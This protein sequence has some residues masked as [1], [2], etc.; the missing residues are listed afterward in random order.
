MMRARAVT[1]LVALA[2]LLWSSSGS[3]RAVDRLRTVKPDGAGPFPAVLFV[4]GCSGFAPPFAPSAYERPAE[5]LRT[6]G[7][8]VTYVDYLAARGLKTCADALTLF[9]PSE[10]GADLHAEAEGDLLAAATWLGTQPFVDPA[11]ITALGW[12]WGGGVVL[13]TLLHT[14]GDRLGFSRAI[15]YYPDCRA[16]GAWNVQTPLLMLI[17]GADTVMSRKACEAAAKRSAYSDA[18]KVVVYEGAMQGFDVEELP[19]KMS[20]PFGTLGHDP[21]AA[22][23]AWQ[24]IMRF[25]SRQP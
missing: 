2:L 14:T 4:S 7:Y 23:A 15:V 16:M 20:S 8:V 22:T 24:E 6:A 10:A 19:A 11:R 13:S 17:A 25:L 5:R 12:S 18:V 9:P 3:A 21:A 1:G